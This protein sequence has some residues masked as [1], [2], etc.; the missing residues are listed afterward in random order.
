MTASYQVMDIQEEC[1]QTKPK[2]DSN[3][4]STSRIATVME[5]IIKK[6]IK[7]V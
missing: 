2:K 4:H 6:P 3:Y 7:A 1:I 5:S